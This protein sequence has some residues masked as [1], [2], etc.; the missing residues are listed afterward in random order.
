VKAPTAQMTIHPP[1]FRQEAHMLTDPLYHG[2]A[3]LFDSFS[4]TH[5]GAGAN[6]SNGALGVWVTP[7][8]N[9]ATSFGGNYS[10][11]LY[12]VF[13]APGV[14][15]EVPLEW[16]VDHHEEARAIEIAKGRDAAIHYYE[17]IRQEFLTDGYDQ[18]WVVERDGSA[19]TRVILNPDSI[20]ILSVSEITSLSAA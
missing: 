17:S 10:G 5:A 12:T 15:K 11:Y 6:A 7:E 13:T 4:L 18:I 14:V 9:I 20:G 1:L 3:S 19:P 2:S 8:L 16:L